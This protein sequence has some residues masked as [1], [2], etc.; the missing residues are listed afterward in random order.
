MQPNIEQVKSAIRWLVATFGGLVMGWAA[1]RGWDL[2]GLLSLMNPEALIS[3]AATMVVL[4]WSMFSNSKVGII[5]AAAK[6]PEVKKVELVPADP[7]PE[8]KK[9]VAR[10]AQSTP[11]EVV[12]R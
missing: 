10:L 12:A 9:E 3:F 11:P 6:I 8:A 4:V 1:A 7:S 2:S 5:T